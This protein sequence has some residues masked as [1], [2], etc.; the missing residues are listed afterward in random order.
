MAVSEGRICAAS[1][2]FPGGGFR[3]NGR[4]VEVAVLP[5]AGAFTTGALPAGCGKEASRPGMA[6]PAR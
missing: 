4:V 2:G 1:G 3:W 5:A 6:T